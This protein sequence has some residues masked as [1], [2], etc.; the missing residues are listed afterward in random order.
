MPPSEPR[1]GPEDDRKIPCDGAPLSGFHIAVRDW[2]KHTFAKPTPPQVEAWRAIAGGGHVLLAAPTGSGKTLAAFLAAIDRLVKEAE[3]GQLADEVRVIYVSPLKALSNDIQRNLAGPLTNICGRLEGACAN[4]CAGREANPR[5]MIRAA[6][7]TGDTT[8]AERTRMLKKPP[9]ILVTTP[10]SLYILL[11]SDSGRKML[12]TSETLIIDEIHALAG[13]KRGAHLALSAERLQGLCEARC[14]GLREGLRERQCEGRREGRRA[15]ALTRIGLSATQEPVDAVAA[16]LVGAARNPTCTVIN[17]GHLRPRDIQIELTASPLQAVMSGDGWS[18]IYHRLEQ[19][20]HA[21]RTTLIF[22]NT[23]HM[24][25]RM[26]KA[27]SERLDENSVTAHHGSLA[28]EHRLDAEQRL[29]AGTLRALV[30]T[31]SLELGIDIGDID[32]VCQVGSCRGL[33]VFLQR[34]GRSGHRLDAIPKGRLFPLSRDDLVECV[35]IVEA[36]TGGKLDPL[37]SCREPLEVLA[38][39]LVAEVAA[40]ERSV[41]ELYQLVR[42]ADPYRALEREK[43]DEVVQM[44]ADGFSTR[45]GRRSAYLH[46][47]AVNGRVRPRRGARLT[48]ITNGG[49]IAEQFDYDVILEPGG[50]RIGTLNEDFS[51]ESLPGDVFQLG[52]SAYRILRV[53]PGKV[54]VNDASGQPPTI[55]FWLGRAP[56]RSDALSEAVSNLRQRV[57]EWLPEGA[58]RAAKR[59]AAA[60]HI[61]GR[62]ATQLT[63]YLGAA[64]A[65]LGALPSMDTV[66]FE[67]F[68]DQAGDQHLVV[69]STFGS[70]VNRA[71]GLALRKR[72]CRKFNFELQ[73]AALE[74]VL[75]LSL[76]STHSFVLE[77]AVTYLNAATVREVL[78]QA[79]L[80]APMFPTQWRWNASTALAVKRFAGGRKNPPQFQRSDAEDLLAVVFPDQIACRENIAGEREIPHHPLVEQTLKD[81]LNDWMDIA[82]LEEILGDIRAGRIAVVCRDL[83]APS[84]LAEEA[85]GARPHTFLDDAPA[86]E[87]R[88]SLVSSLS[89]AGRFL[90]P[91]DAALLG[92]LSVRAIREVRAEAWP[93]V[94]DADECHDAL[95]I[96]GALSGAEADACGWRHWLQELVSQRRATR[97]QTAGV[98]LWVAA[99]RLAI[100]QALHPGGSLHPQIAA[101]GGLGASKSLES[102]ESPETLPTDDALRELLRFR[103]QGTGP[104]TAAQLA[105]LLDLPRASME[106]ALAALEREG[107]AMRGYFEPEPEPGSASESGAE[108]E[109]DAAESAWQWCERGLLARIHRR[110]IKGLRAEVRP[111]GVAGFMRF[112]FRWQGIDEEGRGELD[113]AEALDALLEQLEGVEVP[114]AAWESEVLPLRIN[115]YLGHWLDGL[116]AGGAIRWGRL[117]P[118]DKSGASGKP[119]G[120]GKSSL[121]VTPIALVRRRALKHW[122]ACGRLADPR[123]LTANARRILEIL[124]QRGPQFFDELL[125]CGGWLKSEVENALSELAARGFAASDSFCGLRALASPAAR[126]SARRSRHSRQRGRGRVADLDNAG[127]WFL[128]R[129]NPPTAAPT[130]VPTKDRWEPV[131]YIA[132]VL[133]K[134]YGVVFRNLLE[135]ENNLPRWRDLQ[136]MY[137]RME[138]RGEVRGGRFVEG[139]SGEQF[140]LPEAVGLLRRMERADGHGLV[141]ISAADPLNL[142]GILLPGERAPA[143]SNNRILFRGGTPIA[144]L[145][146]GTLAWLEPLP[147]AQQQDARRR[148]ISVPGAKARRAKRAAGVLPKALANTPDLLPNAVPNATPN[149]ASKAAPNTTSNATPKRPS[150][151][152]SA[153]SGVTLPAGARK[154]R[155]TRG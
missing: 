117:N 89:R 54:M 111:A 121:K 62:A 106:R 67:R 142:T 145:T 23:R 65:A 59:A 96:L 88:T 125:D 105:A 152:Q 38:Q 150:H 13:N 48:A 131:A 58:G 138:G 15:T 90:P 27:L 122:L 87:R 103:L 146:A 100:L 153:W 143:L 14:E 91:E 95:M 22:V 26:A 24:A 72:F 39:Q 134:R 37:S 25:E 108:P 4:P 129:G 104:V 19:L 41:D 9:H 44:L 35:A 8:A 139:F 136:Y 68:F 81:C 64:Q 119:A 12:R 32:L 28:K 21:H 52:N 126:K 46:L 113:G 82:R 141:S 7:R 6:V 116:C 56:G 124:G 31:A 140:A 43:F 47:D 147:E 109:P 101:T 154:G 128:L 69:H 97:L 86:E 77:E 75:V 80:E 18:E 132:A 137:R 148:L 130:E 17:H 30:A 83:V 71:W 115:G 99:E 45:R 10:E 84:P 114:G 93:A 118:P 57:A 3:R 33:S 94:R 120:P 135:G 144:T 63:D 74:D 127:R 11:T 42:R 51:F 107:Y 20:I 34:V 98:T 29:K 112:L 40:G 49:T 2:F 61:D 16:Y 5:P 123:Q 110:T 76:G 102:P 36:V 79:L 92:H 151:R 85:L 70:R 73:A 60:F 66:I 53:E 55:P 155:I 78:I 1:K 50:F 133:L 149:A